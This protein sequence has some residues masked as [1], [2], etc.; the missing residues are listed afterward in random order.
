MTRTK[1][2]AYPDN[3]DFDY[4]GPY[5]A[6]WYDEA[7]AECYTEATDWNGNNHIS[8]A[9][10]SQTEHERLDRTA[11]GRWVLHSWSQW[12]GTLPTVRFVADE[13][14]RQWLVLNDHD[15]AVAEYFGM[16]D[17]AGPTPIDLGGRPSIGGEAKVSYGT[18]RLAR[19]D[20]AAA[21]AGLTRAEW[22]RRAAEAAL[23]SS[24][25]ATAPAE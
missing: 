12:Q 22:L 20:D 18:E 21:A 3:D 8:R 13:A 17:E 1:V 24:L 2:M 5:V 19:I 4:E 6:G 25:E 15:E 16:D 11:G 7:K 9:T 23:R 10:G 14:A